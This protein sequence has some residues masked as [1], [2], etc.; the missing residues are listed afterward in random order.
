MHHQDDIQEK[1]WVGR[2]GRGADW[3]ETKRR[4]AGSALHVD[5]ALHGR[6]TFPPLDRFLP[7]GTVAVENKAPGTYLRLVELVGFYGRV[8]LLIERGLQEGAPWRAD[9][10]ISGLIVTSR[11]AREAE[12]AVPFAAQPPYAG[13]RSLSGPLFGLYVWEVDRIEAVPEHMPWIL[14]F[15]SDRRLREVLSEVDLE[16]PAP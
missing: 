12:Q 3:L 16:L 1:A 2:L 10:A 14:L 6:L 15:A 11:L 7:N 8:A 13:V 4:V 5:V 9:E